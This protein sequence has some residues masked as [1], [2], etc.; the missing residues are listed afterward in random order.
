[1]SATNFLLKASPAPSLSI[2]ITYLTFASVPI[3]PY[4]FSLP[5]RLYLKAKIY[6]E[7]EPYPE[8]LT[9]ILDILS[10]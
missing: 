6:V 1:M 9:A 2:T 3:P 10:L 5:P 4:S 8:D 7:C